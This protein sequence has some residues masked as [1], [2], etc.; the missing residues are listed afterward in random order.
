MPSLVFIADFYVLWNWN[1]FEVALLWLFWVIHLWIRGS[2]RSKDG[3]KKVAFQH[4]EM[5]LCSVLLLSGE[6]H[7]SLCH[8]VKFPFT[9]MAVL[10][11][12]LTA[13]AE[14]SVSFSPA[15]T[16][17]LC[18]CSSGN[19]IDSHLSSGSPVTVMAT[20]LWLSHG[21]W[22]CLVVMLRNGPRVPWNLE[23]M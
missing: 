2:I 20:F 15:G 18:L 23:V 5:S 14:L 21:K 3:K 9:Q 16:L 6:T 1:V 13:D 8:P 4:V 11:L 19:F 12:S 7:N 10:S 17:S 22:R